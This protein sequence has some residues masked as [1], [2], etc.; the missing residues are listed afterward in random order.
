MRRESK[1]IVVTVIAMRRISINS[2]V[3]R[4]AEMKCTAL[5]VNQVVDIDTVAAIIVAIV[6]VMGGRSI[7]SVIFAL[8]LPSY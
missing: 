8:S 6:I 1:V 5:V 3:M 2:T 4:V 7:M